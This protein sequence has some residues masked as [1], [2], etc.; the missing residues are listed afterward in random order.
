MKIFIA[1]SKHFYHKI[2]EIKNNLEQRGHEV[3]LPNSYDNPFKEEEIKNLSKEEHIKWKASMMKKDKVSIEP[4]DAV[5]VL[6][7]EKNG[8]PNYIGGATFL[9]L[10]KSWELNKKIFLFNAIPDCKLKDEIIGMDPTVINGDLT[11]IK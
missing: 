6:N 8:Q 5:L 11:K 1:C 9:E 4:N 10:Y 3:A 2:R 7:F